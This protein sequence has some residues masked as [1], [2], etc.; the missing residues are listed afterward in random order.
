VE[1]VKNKWIVIG[2]VHIDSGTILICGPCQ[3]HHSPG[4]TEIVIAKPDGNYDP[5]QIGEG[6]GVLVST[7]L[8]DGAYDVRFIGPG[9]MYNL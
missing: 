8:G 3:T 1:T 4:F 6:V 7:A 5:H 9:T 2:Q